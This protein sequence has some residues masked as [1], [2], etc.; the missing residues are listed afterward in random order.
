[1]IWLLKLNYKCIDLQISHP[2]A[3]L[4]FSDSQ[5]PIHIV[6]NP[7]FHER[8]KRIEIDWYLVRD[9]IQEGIIWNLHVPS[10]HQVADIMTKALGFPLFSSLVVEMGMH[11]LCAPF[12]GGVLKLNYKCIELNDREVE[13]RNKEDRMKT[14]AAWGEDKNRARAS[15]MANS[16][17]VIPD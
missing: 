3:V 17:A 8:T 10:K 14:T 11:N 1:M 12:W 4:L 2:N 15:H 7:V 5:A 6:A 13:A 9:K 16:T